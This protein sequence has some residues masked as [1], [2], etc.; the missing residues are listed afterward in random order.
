MV[1]EINEKAMEINVK[2]GESK[3][4]IITLYSQNMKEIVKMLKREIKEGKE[5][6]LLIGGDYNARIGR[7][8]NRVK[9]EKRQEN[10]KTR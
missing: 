10:Q 6:Y 4:K 2:L 3:W 1:K 5:E 8:T 9:K 7:R